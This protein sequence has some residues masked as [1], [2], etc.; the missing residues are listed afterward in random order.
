MGAIGAVPIAAMPMET[1][2][3]TYF[4]KFKIGWW[5]YKQTIGVFGTLVDT[6][7]FEVSWST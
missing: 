3:Y 6:E 2:E 7:T 1:F 4:A 5:D